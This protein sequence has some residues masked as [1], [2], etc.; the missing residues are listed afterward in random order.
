MSEE[1]SFKE[2]FDA[3]I[4]LIDVEKERYNHLRLEHKKAKKKL[5]ATLLRLDEMKLKFESFKEQE[6]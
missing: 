5:A 6:P 2:K 1:K 3:I 4:K